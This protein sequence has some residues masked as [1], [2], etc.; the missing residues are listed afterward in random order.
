MSSV[1]TCE[2]SGE[3][4]TSGEVAVVTPSGHICLKRL[5]L[6]QLTTNGGQ[7]PFST[8][9]PLT[10][11]E[12]VELKPASKVLIP[13]PRTSQFTQTLQQLQQD[14]DAVLLELF[15][16]RKLLADT[17]QELSQALY[18]N[19]AAVRVVA[20][21]SAEYD[22]VRNTMLKEGGKR[23]AVETTT[24]PAAKKMKSTATNIASAIPES[25]F[26]IMSKTWE[27]L[28]GARKATQKQLAKEA[29]TLESL[30][31]VESVALKVAAA[32]KGALTSLV[33]T[34]AGDDTALVFVTGTSITLVENAEAKSTPKLSTASQATSAA[35]FA[36]DDVVVGLADG[37]VLRSGSKLEPIDDGSPI[38]AITVHPD[39]THFVA[40]TASGNVAV[41]KDQEW[42]AA[43]TGNDKPYTVGTLHPDG[44]IYIAG[45]TSGNLHFWDFKN[46]SL[47]G[48]MDYTAGAAVQAVAFS[49]NGYYIASAYSNGHVL[50]WDL[51]K[52]SILTTLNEEGDLAAVSSVAFD[53]SGK[54]LAYSGQTKKGMAVQ[55]V[56]VKHWDQ[57][58]LLAGPSKSKSS[59]GL[60]WNKKGI[61]A[62]ASSGRQSLVVQFDV[63]SI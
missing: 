16:T 32:K 35:A 40:A 19:D 14:Y 38:V 28:H 13:P 41:A 3:S 57:S 8:G 5:L 20:R 30:G 11:D 60:T 50:V 22:Q 45:T 58:V 31:K 2:L 44:L 26:A 12:L 52:Q 49:N 47:G 48:S 61:A 9:R 63:P 42:V 51:R 17:R 62:C 37:S 29:P 43:F 34:S 36:S 18:Q 56:T 59:N 7:D 25:D 6:Q 4:V 10:E 53:E 15:D 1:L 46:Q 21:L 33:T 24:E 55:V 27:E 54:Y 39:A 23:L